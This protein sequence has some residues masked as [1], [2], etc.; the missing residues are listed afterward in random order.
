MSIPNK[1]I[2]I[3]LQGVKLENYDKLAD[4]SKYIYGYKKPNEYISRL[5]FV[6]FTVL[7]TLTDFTSSIVLFSS[8]DISL[9]PWF[10]P[11]GFYITFFT[12]TSKN[13][14]WYAF[15][16]HYIRA[17][18]SLYNRDL[19]TIIVVTVWITIKLIV[20]AIETILLDKVGM[21]LRLNRYT[22]IMKLSAVTLILHTFIG[23]LSLVRGQILGFESEEKFFDS[24]V[25]GLGD[26]IGISTV[27]ILF[28]K[29]EK[30]MKYILED[31]MSSFRIIVQLTILLICSLS[32]LTLILVT[33]SLFAFLIFVVIPLLPIIISLAYSIN[34]MVITMTIYNTVI[35]D[36]VLFL[37]DD[38]TTSSGLLVLQVFLIVPYIIG[39]VM[40]GVVEELKLEEKDKN[41][42]IE[43][44]SDV[45]IKT[46]LRFNILYANISVKNVM[47]YNQTELIG[48]NLLSLIHEE[49]KDGVKN[50]LKLK[51]GR[52][53]I[54][55]QVINKPKRII[56]VL[57]TFYI[58]DCY[59]F[60]LRDI[61]EL[62]QISKSK[63]SFLANMSHEIRTPMNGIMGIISIL[64]LKIKEEENTKLLGMCM[65]SCKSLMHILNDIL[66]FSKAEVG[67]IQLEKEEF[68]IRELIN[69]IV[70][71]FVVEK[72]DVELILN[73]PDEVPTF[74][75]GDSGRLRQVLVNL[76]GNSYKFTERGDIVISID[77][78]DFNKETNTCE[79]T[80][81]IRDSGIGMS[82]ETV[83]GLF[84]PFYQADVSTTRKY[85]G[86]G[87][88]LSICKKI[89]ELF[90]GN[91]IAESILGI[92]SNFIFTAKFGTST[93][94]E[95]I[96]YPENYLEDINILIVDDNKTNRFVLDRYLTDKKANVI[97]AEDGP[98]AIRLLK[99]TKSNFNKIDIL[100][101][102][103][104]MPGMDGIECI[105]K[106]LEIDGDLKCIL[107]PSYIEEKT[108]EKCDIKYITKPLTKEKLYQKLSEM[109][110]K[111]K[112]I[113]E[114]IGVM[115]IEDDSVNQFLLTNL[116]DTH[117][118][119]LNY[120]V[121]NNGLEALQKLN[122]VEPELIILD[123]HMPKM[124]GFELLKSLHKNPDEEFN[125]PT[126]IYTADITSENIARL[127]PYK[128]IKDIVY[129]PIDL[130]VLKEIVD[131][132]TT[133]PMTIRGDLQ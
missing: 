5:E 39:L 35:Y 119:D 37:S 50:F 63:S 59:H 29:Y 12:Y 123:L 27:F 58:T 14:W 4:I 46:D 118:K 132:Y 65:N 110:P 94:E 10:F 117:F 98:M 53:G 97:S 3:E 92:G 60:V 82:S 51:D 45:Y 75:I 105:T 73:I 49:S 1:E 20:Y 111:K 19:F 76:I 78:N 61:T 40:A 34:S 9:S 108:I 2:D 56:D 38:N 109:L 100:L 89:I 24:L 113:K 83:N 64:Q 79:L 33:D 28:Y 66:L 22:D 31:I 77:I 115:V 102:D 47:N 41:K 18:L 15:L 91:I 11:A 107:L 125:I 25:W 7:F 95:Q 99:E 116:L 121:M 88:G 67:R 80:F 87:L 71:M 68:N 36:I 62:K 8:R 84:N 112:T 114:K 69:E 52:E 13:N 130:N 26:I 106:C 6:L 74:L 126:I 54:E 120:T 48:K 96:V 122:V 127:D 70:I 90:E 57:L 129:K 17:A 131:K 43:N 72:T 133:N 103:Y 44:L 86:T 81:Q 104:N 124:D 101:S 42:V 32:V 23:Y 93:H 16:L 55:I 21:N 30:K 85:G 128:N